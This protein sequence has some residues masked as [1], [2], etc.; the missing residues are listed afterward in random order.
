MA[1]PITQ[2]IHDRLRNST[3]LTSLISS[4]IGNPAIFTAFPIPKGAN[5]PYIVTTG[6]VSQIDQDT[7]SS[8]GR[9]I[10]R[11]INC[12]AD[13]SGNSSKIEDISNVIR[14]L[15]HRY[16]IQI[17]G[18]EVSVSRVSGPI[19]INDKD[20]YGRSLTLNMKLHELRR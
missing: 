19:I 3:A 17:V 20:V 15:F 1:D 12:Y 4:Y 5:L 10:I 16:Q 14:T 6:F 18:F 2:A 13:Q 11:D 9:E 7:L 8:Y